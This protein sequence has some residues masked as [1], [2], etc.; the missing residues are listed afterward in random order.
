M[1]PNISYTTLKQ[2]QS[3]NKRQMS[4]FIS[5]IYESGYK[6]GYESCKMEKG[7]EIDFDLLKIAIKATEGVG[8]TLY[9]RLVQ[10]IDRLCF[11]ET[12]DN[13]DVEQ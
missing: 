4:A 6:D 12:K 7:N 8:D 13:K 10:T 1:K 3:Y 9:N 11:T 5:S 2:I